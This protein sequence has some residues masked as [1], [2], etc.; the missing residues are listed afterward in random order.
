MIIIVIII[1]GGLL[2]NFAYGKTMVFFKVMTK[3]YSDFNNHFGCLLKVRLQQHVAT[4][5]TLLSMC[6]AVGNLP[7]EWEGGK[8]GQ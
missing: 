3:Y 8:T 2:H 1:K 6:K 5:N 7:S 4:S